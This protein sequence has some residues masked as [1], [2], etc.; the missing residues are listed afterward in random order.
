MLK[1]ILV[2]ATLAA[3][4]YSQTADPTSI[5]LSGCGTTGSLNRDIEIDENYDPAKI[6]G[7][8]EA[9]QHFWRWQVGLQR[10]GSAICGGS[11]INSQWIMTAAHCTNG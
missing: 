9:Q 2:L 7:G 11:I 3:V 1:A 8:V 6:V 5:N 10:S 4:A